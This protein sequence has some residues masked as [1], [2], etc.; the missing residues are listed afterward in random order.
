MQTAKARRN[1]LLCYPEK[2]EFG[3]CES[4]WRQAVVLPEETKV[5]I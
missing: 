1:K 3:G 4:E 2:P 5:W